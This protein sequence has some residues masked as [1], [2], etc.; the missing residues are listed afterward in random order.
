MVSSLERELAAQGAIV[1]S[2]RV[3]RVAS[4]PKGEMAKAPL[5]LA[6]VPQPAR[7]EH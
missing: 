1:P 4:I 5:I 3:R 7:E 2:V 6:G